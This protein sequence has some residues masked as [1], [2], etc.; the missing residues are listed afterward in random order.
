MFKP[1]WIACSAS[2]AAELEFTPSEP[3]QGCGSAL[4]KSLDIL[5]TEA[6]YSLGAL[7]AT[8]LDR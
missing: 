8:H 6:L 7:P 4:G 1:G 5:R 2:A 3:W